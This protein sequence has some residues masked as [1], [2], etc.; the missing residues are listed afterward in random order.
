MVFKF[1]PENGTSGKQPFAAP[2]DVTGAANG[3]RLTRVGRSHRRGFARYIS[4]TGVWDCGVQIMHCLTLV[5]AHRIAE[6]PVSVRNSNGDAFRRSVK[7]E[8]ICRAIGQKQALE[9]DRPDPVTQKAVCRQSCKRPS[10]R[11]ENRKSRAVSL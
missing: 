5:H 11:E 2:V 4:G 3:C 6:I 7:A 9:S 1:C 8:C 10:T